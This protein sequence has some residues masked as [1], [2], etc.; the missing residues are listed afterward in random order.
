MEG[1]SFPEGGT[2]PHEYATST[3][4]TLPQ[5]FHPCGTLWQRVGCGTLHNVFHRRP[6]GRIQTFYE[7]PSPC[8]RVPFQKGAGPSTTFHKGTSR[9]GFQPF[10]KGSNPSRRV[11]TLP[12]GCAPFQKGTLPA[13]F[14]PFRKGL[15]LPEGCGPFWKGSLLE[16]S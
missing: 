11:S 8:K 12:E 5:G 4:P 2:L 13:G 10:Q 16:G 6:Q 7:A 14:Q 9:A 3:L 15:T 1:F